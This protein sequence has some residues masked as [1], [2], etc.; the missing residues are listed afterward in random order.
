M[1]RMRGT[2]GN[3]N[4]RPAPVPRARGE[5][6]AGSRRVRYTRVTMERTF[7]VLGALSAC[8]AVGLGAFGAHG[9]KSRVSPEM[10]AVFDT[11]ARYQMY[12]ALGL[13]A[14]GLAAAR[15]PGS[16]ALSW[17]GW[18]FVAGT[19][20]FSGSLYALVLTGVKGLGAVTPVGGLAFMAGW[21]AF[22]A[23]VLSAGG[24]GS[25]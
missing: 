9:L 5:P 8:I 24:R 3:G 14:A 13:L 18:L 21:I 7:V 12:H 22:A 4:A 11:A 20:L 2:R 17:A 23:A 16:Q 10:V 25:P 1:P 6:R 19:A 15:W